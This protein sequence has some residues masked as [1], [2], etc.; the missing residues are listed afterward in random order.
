MAFDTPENR[1]RFDV[2]MTEHDKWFNHNS[3]NGV[4]YTR[5]WNGDDW[6]KVTDDFEHWCAGRE[7]KKKQ[8]TTKDMEGS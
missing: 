1:H 3:R 4:S 8:S 7:N 5:G 6:R 2:A